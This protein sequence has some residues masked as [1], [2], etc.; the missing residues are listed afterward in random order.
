L[1]NDVENIQLEAPDTPNTNGVPYV[2]VEELRYNDRA[3]WPQA[4]DG[5]GFSLQRRNPAGFANS[6]SNWLAAIPTPGRLLASADTDGDGMP[7]VW[8]IQ[9]G[10][11]PLVPDADQ[12]PDGDGLTNLEEYL[13]GTDPLSAQSALKLTAVVSAPGSLALSFLAVSNRSY[14]VVY[15]TSLSDPIWLNLTNV[16]VQPTNCLISIP[17]S[18]LG[19][20]RYYRLVTPALP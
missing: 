7:D 3:P 16:V 14:S 17:Q 19:A 11:N 15:R 5:S 20:T 6:P 10:T 12:D 13:S 4:A 9:F 1:Q 18:P 2:A 8:E